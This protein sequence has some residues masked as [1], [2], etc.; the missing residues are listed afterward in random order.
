MAVFRFDG[1]TGITGLRV[2]SRLWFVQCLGFG[3]I[4]AGAVVD[5][6]Y[7]AWWSGRS[8]LDRIG[9]LGHLVTLAGMVLVMVTVIGAGLRRRPS[10]HRTKGEHHVAR[11][12]PSAS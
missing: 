12:R 10:I 3:L 5:A 7:H 11:R 4:V 1:R 8:D 9:L 6:V 2:G